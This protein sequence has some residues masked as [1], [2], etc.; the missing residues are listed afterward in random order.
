[1]EEE[2]KSFIREECSGI[3]DSK[4]VS[5]ETVEHPFEDANSNE[6]DDEEIVISL[7]TIPI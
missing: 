2:L 7:R 3:G 5:N 4:I 1:M 6:V